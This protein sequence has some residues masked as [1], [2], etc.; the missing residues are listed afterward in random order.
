MSVKITKQ[1]DRCGFCET[2]DDGETFKTIHK[3]CLSNISKIDEKAV[4]ADLCISCSIQ[5][6]N[7]MLGRS[8]ESD[9]K[10]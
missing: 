7:N 1:C 6:A 4:S 3:F 8:R 10:V 9:Q 2:V 5:I